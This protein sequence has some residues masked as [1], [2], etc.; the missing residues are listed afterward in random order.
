[1][2]ASVFDLTKGK[3]IES[4]EGAVYKILSNRPQTAGTVGKN[5]IEP[6]FVVMVRREDRGD[7]KAFDLFISQTSL[8][9]GHYSLRE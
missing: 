8:D 1:M 2:T 5:G 3:L 6:N 7:G 9:L 4:G